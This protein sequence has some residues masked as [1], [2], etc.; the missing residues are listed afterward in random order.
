MKQ[1][2]KNVGLVALAI[3]CTAVFAFLAAYF[4]DISEWFLSLNKGPLM[5]PGPVFQIGWGILYVLLAASFAIVLVKCEGGGW[6]PYLVNLALLALW[7]YVFFERRQIG[8]AFLL[9][10]CIAV[11]SI[12]LF[13][14]AYKRSKL[15]GYLLLPFVAWMG[16]A[17]ALNY[18]IVILNG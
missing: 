11:E 17:T 10:V 6:L 5:P 3:V 7:C 12:L 18:Y 16:F 15:A 14:Y 2:A 13:G 4:T 8:T 9:I 1:T